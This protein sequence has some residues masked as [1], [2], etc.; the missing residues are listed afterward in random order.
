VCQGAAGVKRG[1]GSRG[2]GEVAVVL[3]PWQHS[4]T[5]HSNTVTQHH[6]TRTGCAAKHRC[7]CREEGC[8]IHIVQVASQQ[9]AEHNSSRAGQVWAQ[10]GSRGRR[11]QQQLWSILGLQSSSGVCDCGVCDCGVCDC[12][13]C[14]SG[15]CDSVTSHSQHTWIAMRPCCCL[16]CCTG[17]SL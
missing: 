3:R 8:V 13:V 12:G 7:V 17:W 1:M 15:V 14:D 4:I 10:V 9:L 16:P 11:R 6:P 2:S 5:T